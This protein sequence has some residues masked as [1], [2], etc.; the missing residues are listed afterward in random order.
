MGT[1]L[2][3]VIQKMPPPG[4]IFATDLTRTRV[5]SPEVAE[6]FTALMRADNKL[7][8]AAALL[9]AG[10]GTFSLQVDRLVKEA[11]FGSRQAFHN[12][13]DLESWLTP[14]LTPEEMQAFGQQFKPAAPSP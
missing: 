12:R 11:G 2:R 14:R 5:V 10:Q 8:I 9:T 3:T 4:A 6:S 7:L 13:L 1:E